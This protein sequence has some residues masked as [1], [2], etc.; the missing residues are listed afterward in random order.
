LDDESFDEIAERARKGINK[1]FPGW[2]DYNLHDPGI[3]FIE[4]FAWL[5]E[6][7]QYHLDQVSNASR[8][9][10]LKLLGIK[11][12]EK[13]PAKASVRVYDL[14][15]DMV[16]PQGTRLLADHVMFETIRRE[17]LTNGR[18][19][20]GYTLKRGGERIDFDHLLTEG[21]KMR[22]PLFG[23]EP[24]KGDAFWIRL[25]KP[26]P[27]GE[28][29]SIYIDVF[30]DYDVRR[31]M[32]SED[33]IP[34]ARVDW[35]Y[36]TAD[37][38]TS[39]DVTDDDTCQFLQDG[40]VHFTFSREMAPLLG[41][42]GY[43]MRATLAS[44]DYEVAPVLD[45]IHLT[46]IPAVQKATMSQY[47]DFQ[48]SEGVTNARGE[49]V[50]IWDTDLAIRGMSEVYIGR[51]ISGDLI[52]WEK[53][54]DFRK[55]AGRREARF[56]LRSSLME[57]GMA[58]RI[59]C[60][61]EGFSLRRMVG[62][63]DGF[64]YQSFD[65]EADDLLETDFQIMVREKA[66]YVEWEKVEDF[67]QSDPESRHYIMDE[68][69]GLLVFGD[70]EQGLAP[71]GDILL[72]SCAI[73]QGEGGNVKEGRINAFAGY[74]IPAKVANHRVAAGGA[75]SESIDE[76]FLRAR[77]DLRRW[78]RAVTYED[79]E[80]LV[81]D[82]P[83][84]MIQNCK[85]IPVTKNPRRDGSMD[86]NAVSV[87]V[88]PFSIGEKR[89]LN[90]S[91]M[92]NIYQHLEDKRLIGTRINVLSPEYIGIRVYAEILIKPY[93]L[94]AAERIRRAV[95]DFFGSA[96]WDFGKTVQYSAIYGV[97]DTLDCVLGIQALTV[98]AQG[99]GIMRGVNGD[100]NLPQNGMAFLQ[101][102]EYMINEGEV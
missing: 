95:E 25:D 99:K 18:I 16:L 70:G 94:D 11:P 84:L 5:K 101:E 48:R 56:H 71:E 4:L 23:Q 26:L 77:R 96:A 87:V 15:E 50:F 88:Q 55:E 79:Y 54:G 7:Q 67:D 12:G 98:D 90:Q 53:T 52:Y 17:Y 37:G 43:W 42:E 35:E 82:T 8:K 58:L 81:R 73:S 93:Y 2:T 65:L 32:P 34:L 47:K 68:S 69:T 29:H 46:M 86:E 97:I 102:A 38:W 61:E 41:P 51:K 49:R 100:V 14:E 66:G 24:E 1:Y 91:Y 20:G 21:G 64:P 57:E 89:K 59:V 31:N 27:P 19:T 6:I 33:F 13:Q 22:F 28:A 75:G 30:E 39:L 83:G 9:K 85:A 74:G 63:G 76:A 36:H 44:S 10:F 92:E 3:T 60:Y 80:N 62:Q 45:G 72:V 40:R 78:S